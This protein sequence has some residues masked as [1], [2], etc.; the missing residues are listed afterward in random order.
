MHWQD[1]VPIF[2][3]AL[4]VERASSPRTLRSYE[5]DLGH[6]FTWL[7]EERGITEAD[8]VDVRDIRRYLAR[9]FRLHARST[10]ARRLSALRSFYRMLVRKG[11]LEANP[12]ALV[13]TPKQGKPLSSFLTAS[14]ADALMGAT[15]STQEALALRD[16]A[17]WEVLYS[18]GL[19][20]SELTSLDLGSLDLEAGWLRVLGKGS[21][22]REVPLGTKAI[23]ALGDY[24]EVRVEL[25]DLSPDGDI[26]ALFL[27]ARGGRLTARS[28]RRLLSNAQL[29]SGAANTVSPHGIRHSFA[30]HMLDGGAD[31]RGIQEMLGH[32]SLSTTQKYTHVS[33]DRLMSVYDKAHPRAARRRRRSPLLGEDD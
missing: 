4:R 19:R 28:V 23:T 10:L 11:V 2:L 18:S 9:H 5:G 16:V 1:A 21:K 3:D 26:G 32:S 20:V 7:E 25:S 6:F 13:Q 27:N 22:E 24:L 33:L 30:T 31:L 29:Q 8:V 17:M 15:A 12:A 14:E